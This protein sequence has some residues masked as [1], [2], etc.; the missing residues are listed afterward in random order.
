MNSIERIE[1]YAK[2]DP[3]APRQTV[4]AKRPE[5][6]PLTCEPCISDLAPCMSDLAP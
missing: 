1:S 4:P 3:E 6:A 5:H 2:L